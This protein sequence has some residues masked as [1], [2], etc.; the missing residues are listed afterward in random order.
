MRRRFAEDIRK[1]YPYRPGRDPRSIELYQELRDKGITWNNF[2][3][4]LDERTDEE[5]TCIMNNALHNMCR[6]WIY[7]DRDKRPEVTDRQRA[8]EI[9]DEVVRFIW[10]GWDQKDVPSRF[11]KD[12]SEA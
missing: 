6:W 8:E 4:N 2:L 7:E 5:I 1:S 3:E 12:E 10:I 9:R 11:W